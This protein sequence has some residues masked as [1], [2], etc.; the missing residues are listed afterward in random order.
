L[1]D[2]S[3]EMVVEMTPFRDMDTD[4]FPVTVTIFH[5][6]WELA[7]IVKDIGIDL[8]QTELLR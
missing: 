8:V 3:V 1:I 4:N 5:S 2:K 7:A 6:E